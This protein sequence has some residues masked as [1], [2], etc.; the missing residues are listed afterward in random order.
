LPE[1]KDNTGNLEEPVPIILKGTRVAGQAERLVRIR[2]EITRVEE[3]T[4]VEQIEHEAKIKSDTALESAQ[5]EAERLV[6]EAK[7]EAEGIRTKARNDGDLTAKR[8]ALE[9][10]A[11]LI[12][13]LENEIHTL[14][15]IRADF[16]GSNLGGIINFSCKLAGKILVCELN[17]RP[18][19]IAERAAQLIERMPPDSKITL[20]TSSEDIDVIET[21]LQEAGGPAETL[22]TALRADPSLK[23]GSLRLESDSGRIDAD[24]I[25]SLEKIGDI[26][27]DQAR[28]FTG[29]VN[30]CVGGVDGD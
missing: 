30:Q 10:L 4:R 8:E 20:T 25:G 13:D 11:G 14:R 3:M 12:T 15:A 19:A 7:N 2:R 29:G 16:M 17:S 1:Q 28:N 6:T 27:G 9:K 5:A 21:Y 18:E 24:L 22:N 23:P 26:L